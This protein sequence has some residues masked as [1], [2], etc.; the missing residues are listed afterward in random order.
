MKKVLFIVIL[1]LSVCS[2]FAAQPGFTAIVFPEQQTTRLNETAVYDLTIDSNSRNGEIF[3]VFSPDI[4]WDVR[5]DR[6][7][8]V[9]SKSSLGSKL[10]IRPL[11][12]NPGL[13]GIPLT[14]RKV[15]SSETVRQTVYLELK[16]IVAPISSYLPAFRG[17][18]SMP[19]IVKP[20]ETLV[21]SVNVE[22]LNR[23]NL[24]DVNVK[25]RSNVVNKDYVTALE[26]REKKALVFTTVVDNAVLPQKDLLKMHI[27]KTENGKSYQYELNPLAYEVLQNENVATDEK[28]TSG[29]LVKTNSARISNLGN[30]LRTVSYSMKVNFFR[31]LFSNVY[32]AA[33]VRDGSYVW[34]LP[35]DVGRES[36]I[37]V[38]TNYRPVAVVLFVLIV[39]TAAYFLLRAPLHI[40]KSASI[41]SAQDGNI[42]RIKIQINVKNRSRKKITGINIIDLVPKIADV[43]KKFDS[44]LIAPSQV[45]RNEN[46]GT[47]IK[48]NIDSMDSGEENI[49]TYRINLKFNVVGGATLPVVVAKFVTGDG[50]ERTTFSNRFKVSAVR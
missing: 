20:G 22:N 5:T 27:I 2:V 6:S 41:V 36:T 19:R 32:P 38:V 42:S 4:S 31:R 34:T 1:L 44:E 7:L 3:E 29:F 28:E 33:E 24:T 30:V 17:N 49:L 40:R 16:S 50:I 15:G 23:R 13:Y 18:A 11:N 48:W 25:L 26:P 35:V 21:I 47:L 46:K 45:V 37:S 12:N 43:E 39:C 10:F 9:S 8:L 14:I